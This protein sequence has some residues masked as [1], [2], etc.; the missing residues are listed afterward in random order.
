[1]QAILWD[2]R[3]IHRLA[4]RGNEHAMQQNRA[5]LGEFLELMRADLA[6]GLEYRRYTNTRERRYEADD[7]DERGDIDDDDDD[8]V[9]D[10]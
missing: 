8:D 6:A 9:D 10:G 3:A 1:M 7:D 4:Y 5:L 2:A